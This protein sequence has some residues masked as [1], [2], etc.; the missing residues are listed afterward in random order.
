[1]NILL[2]LAAVVLT[3][4]SGFVAAAA[5][6]R[7]RRGDWVFACMMVLGS[8]CGLVAAFRSM[9][10]IGT[11]VLSQPWSIP[12]GPFQVRLDALAGMFLAQIFLIG[13]AGTVYALGY[14]PA[15][16][17]PQ[18]VGKL[19]IF[20]G[21]MVSGMA[22]LVMAENSV[23]FLFSWEIMA[24]AAFFAVTT[25]DHLPA[26]RESG[27]V[28]LVATRTGTLLIIAMFA[29]LR[30]ATGSFSLAITG[31]SATSSLGTGVF[32]LG[33]L[34]FGMKAG[35]MPL[36]VWLPGAHANAPTHVSALMSGVLIKMGIYGL[37]RLG[38]FFDKIPIWWGLVLFGLGSVSAVL[39]V[40]FAIGQHDLKRLLAY[41]SVENIGII[42]MGL[43]L[44]LLGRATGH[45]SLI[46]LGLAGALLHT[47]NHGLFKAL[48]FFS[49][50]SVI[51]ATQ[52][53]EID[54]LGGLLRKLPWTSI[55]FLIGAVAICGLP[56]LNG[57][58]SELFVYIG[59]L[60]AGSQDLGPVGVVA[61]LGV[62]VLASVGALA[63]ACFVKVFGVVFLG[64]SRS[65]HGHMAKES[66]WSM[67]APMALLAA[68]CAAIGAMPLLVVPI[69]ERATMNWKAEPQQ[70]GLH[71]LLP[72]ATIS[73]LNVT[74][75]L[76]VVLVAIL[77]SIAAPSA[78]TA[79]VPTWD[80]GYSS[81]SPRMQYTASSFAEGLVGMFGSALRPRIHTPTLTQ[82]LPTSSRFESHVPEV[83]LDLFIMPVFRW[84]GR[85]ATWARF[86]QPGSPHLYVTYILAT[87]VVMLFIWH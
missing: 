4:V 39:G 85:V 29:V 16:K 57:F 65:T 36:H 24:I 64:E 7:T 30:A 73:W 32:I 10:S 67:L 76:A 46:A 37:I 49:A 74:L 58:I 21:L 60:R 87:L 31:L 41:H 1:V 54:A 38:S 28:Y 51:R 8:A 22:L 11:S 79:R 43:G 86:I 78:R 71:T 20:Y 19:R 69:L 62:P 81:P 17:H 83:V 26:V 23:L 66:P 34:G 52:T 59:M 80:C 72:L 53:R 6:F 2:A 48:L 14:W 42:V 82:P 77:L 45:A 27:F 40:A 35:L 9:T 75:I 47:W 50:G 55:A 12:G 13:V 5:G 61:T 70:L 15:H 44:A 33:L 25:D 3:G 56:P 18:T 84:L 68:C 63:V